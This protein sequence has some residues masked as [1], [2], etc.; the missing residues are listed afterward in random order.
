MTSTDSTRRGSPPAFD[1][2]VAA[3][4]VAALAARVPVGLAIVLLIAGALRLALWLAYQP[5]IM[6]NPDATAYVLMADQGLFTVDPARPAGY[7]LFMRA[8]HAVSD[9]V[10]VTILLQHLLGI[11]TG[12][13]L[14]ATVRRIGAPRWAGIAAAA[15]VVLS[16]DQIQFEHTLQAES[17]FTFGLAFVLYAAVRSLDEPR[18]II[19]P[20]TTRHAWILAAGLTLGVAAWVRAV[21]V[22]LMPFLALWFVL[23]IPGAWRVR[24]AH[25]ALAGVAAGTILL[26]YFERNDAA[27]GHFGFTGTTGWGLYARTAPIADCSQFEPPPGTSKLCEKTPPLT[28]QGPDFYA[29]VPTSPAYRVFGPPPLG[30]DS[31]RAFGREVIIHQPKYYAWVAFRDF[32]RYFVPGLNDE[33]GYIVD[34]TYLDLDR[35][36]PPVEQDVENNTR[37]YYPDTEAT[38]DGDDLTRLT[39]LQQFLRV[40]PILLLQAA[41]LA[42]VGLWLSPG[43]VRAPLALLLG[44]ALLGLAIPSATISYNA[45]YAVPFAGPLIAAGGVGLWVVLSRLVE[46]RQSL[47]APEASATPS[48]RAASS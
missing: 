19:G 35:R 36:D 11:A 26:I 9:Q 32:A 48:P 27:T 24:L 41:I 20:L 2:R 45:R 38:I 21:G 25:G 39:D 30:D 46:R 13:L 43:R 23:A 8:V 18:S 37:N 5:V 7:P 47:E 17:V 12:L 42:A 1:L 14:Y 6:S 3:R 15:A 34:Y 10:E 40:H 29:W 16:L 44:A 31:L 33:Q 22:P 28:R 4:R